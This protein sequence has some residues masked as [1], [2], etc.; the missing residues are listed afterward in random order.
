MMA[1]T[2]SRNLPSQEQ[3]FKDL[4][5]R[6]IAHM[7]VSPT[8]RLK[9]FFIMFSSV[10]LFFF[11]LYAVIISKLLPYTGWSLLDMVKDDHYFCYLM[12][13]IILPTY[14]VIYLN[15]L[16]ISHFQQN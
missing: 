7:Q 12:P 14:S 8:L 1:D 15:W 13:L 2:S 5:L 16:A 9:G 3:L 11:F 10:I 6:H 4:G